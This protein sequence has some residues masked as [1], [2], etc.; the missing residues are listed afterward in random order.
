MLSVFTVSA[1]G[2]YGQIPP[3]DP[4][5]FLRR[6]PVQRI[7]E[8]PRASGRG[9]EVLPIDPLRRMGE[10]PRD[11]V[12][13]MG[14][15]PRDPV[16]RMGEIPRDTVR[17][18]DEI[19]RDPVRRMGEIPRDPL[20]RR[21]Q[22]P[23]DPMRR[24]GEIPIDPVRRRGEI[25][26]GSM[27]RRGDFPRG[28]RPRGVREFAVARRIAAPT[29]TERRTA[30]RL[31]NTL[32]R[33]MRPR[34]RFRGGRMVMA[35]TQYLD[36]MFVLDSSGSIGASEFDRGLEASKVRWSAKSSYRIYP[37]YEDIQLHTIIALKSNTSI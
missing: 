34:R 5:G 14:E 12:R 37:K 30:R 17:R 4:T 33:A 13:R 9:L 19:P 2:F 35:C 36:F 20:P 26:R 15:I 24:R 27:R 31:I 10:I 1:Q 22:I 18:M 28:S 11:P 23:I 8:L 3:P 7:G 25:P 16:R 21:G 29:A 32:T 6:D